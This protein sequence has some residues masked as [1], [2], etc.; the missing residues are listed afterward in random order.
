MGRL[1]MFN[2]FGGT[3]IYK[4]VGDPISSEREIKQAASK[5]RKA[6][7]L[8]RITSVSMASIGGRRGQRGWQLWATQKSKK[9]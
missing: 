5:V 8:A 6:G 4:R 1:N 3:T 9:A 7:H 2:Y